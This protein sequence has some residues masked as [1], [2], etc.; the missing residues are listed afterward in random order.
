[1]TEWCYIIFFN[2]LIIPTLLGIVIATEFF[3][4]LVKKSRSRLAQCI[5]QK[6]CNQASDQSVDGPIMRS[7]SWN[8]NEETVDKSERAE[9]K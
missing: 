5:L 4:S 3:S 1:M 9:M 6:I 8:I 7:V 2:K